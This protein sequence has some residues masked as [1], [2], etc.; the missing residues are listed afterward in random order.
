MAIMWNIYRS[1]VEGYVMIYLNF[2]L[3][4]EKPESLLQDQLFIEDLYF[5]PEVKPLE[6]EEDVER[7]VV[8]IDLM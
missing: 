3:E 7:G 4:V 5:I 8:V 2:L 6:E 1:L